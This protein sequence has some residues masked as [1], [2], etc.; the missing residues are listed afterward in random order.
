MVITDRSNKTDYGYDDILSNYIQKYT[1]THQ[2]CFII[3]CCDLLAHQG[4]SY[5][6]GRRGHRL[7]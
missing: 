1:V 2:P 3:V 7:V 6:R 4:R 5:Y